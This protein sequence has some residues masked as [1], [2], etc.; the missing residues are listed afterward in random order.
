M[1]TEVF[2]SPRIS[3]VNRAQK[4]LNNFEAQMQTLNGKIHHI[5]FRIL[6]AS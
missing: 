4:Y 5:D 6:T 2:F 1:K 3:G